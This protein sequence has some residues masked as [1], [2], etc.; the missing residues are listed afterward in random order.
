MP[1]FQEQCTCLAD[2][3]KNG[4]DQKPNDGWSNTIGWDKY[5]LSCLKGLQ[6][7]LSL[8]NFGQKGHSYSKGIDG[9]SEKIRAKNRGGLKM[10]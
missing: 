3:N 10:I 9:W 5:A 8:G 4:I 1:C 6:S 2:Q 7:N